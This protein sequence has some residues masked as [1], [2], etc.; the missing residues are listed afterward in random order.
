MKK[1]HLKILICKGYFSKNALIGLTLAYECGRVT[2]V[3]DD[4]IGKRFYTH[5]AHA[6]K[7]AFVQTTAAHDAI[8]GDTR[9]GEFN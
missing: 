3:W 1:N 2:E 5:S 4:S 7:E 9:M 6:Q 8:L